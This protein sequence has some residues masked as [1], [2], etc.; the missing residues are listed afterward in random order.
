MILNIIKRNWKNINL[1]AVLFRIEN[2]FWNISSEWSIKVS[3]KIRNKIH[4]FSVKYEE[5]TDEG[6][7]EAIEGLQSKMAEI[8]KSIEENDIGLNE[9]TN[10]SI[11]NTTNII[12][13]DN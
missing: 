5:A 6:I 8:L 12:V 2:H 13:F 7:E 9:T 3:F 4:H 1:K 11:S 10:T